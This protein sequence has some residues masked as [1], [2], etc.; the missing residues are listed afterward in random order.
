MGVPKPQLAETGFGDLVSWGILPGTRIGYIYASGWFGTSRAEFTQAVYELTQ[1]QQTDGLILDYR[2]NLGRGIFEGDGGL[3]MLFEHPLP[4]VRFGVRARPDDHFKMRMSSTGLPAGYT[5]ESPSNGTIDPRSYDR[6]IA[7]LTGPGAL[8]AGDQIALRTALHP[9]ARTFGKSTAGAFNA[10]VRP[11][12]DPN[13]YTAYAFADAV[14][15]DSP[16]DFLTHDEFPVDEPVWL[17]ADDAAAGRDSVVE[18]AR[19]W[20]E[21]EG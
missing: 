4:T 17:T 1:Q 6:P 15:L 11:S 21:G 16:K 3:D 19:S 7:I 8:S 14:R 18:A 20:I 13:W 12:L 9:R 5:I 2:F 10:P